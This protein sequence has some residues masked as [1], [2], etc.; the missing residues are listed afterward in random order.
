M[1]PIGIFGGS[2]DPIHFGHLQTA[3]VI[4]QVL[5]FDEVCF[6]PLGIPP[7]R[8]SPIAE[9]KLRLEMVQIAIKDQ[10]GFT[11]DDREIIKKEPSYSVNTLKEFRQENPLRSICMILGMDTFLSL[12]EWYKWAEI[13]EFCHII[14][15]NRPGWRVP[16]VGI[17]GDLVS[18]RNT[19]C[20][21]DLHNENFGRIYFHDVF[22]LQISSSDIRKLL[23]IG[24]DPCFLLPDSVLEIIK[25]S[26][27]YLNYKA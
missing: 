14:V 8:E 15:A 23:G 27:C 21:Q 2:F 10:H 24:C 11:F 25:E 17:I 18:K 1:N 4:K 16:D 26:R 20:I 9:A 12:P 7:H 19:N 22:Q 5:N 6:I 3:F 13:L